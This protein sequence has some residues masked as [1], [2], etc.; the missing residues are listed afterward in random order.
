MKEAGSTITCWVCH[1]QTGPNSDLSVREWR[2]SQCNTLHH[3]DLNSGYNMLWKTEYE[4]ASARGG[5]DT[6]PTVTR[7][8]IQGDETEGRKSEL[9]YGSSGRGNT[10]FYEH[11]GVALPNLW[12]EEVPKALKSLIHMKIVRPLTMQTGAETGSGT[13]P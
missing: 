8:K 12:N 2:C 10:F 3:R 6:V 4:I 1:E 5:T 13:P 7:T 9:R 11:A